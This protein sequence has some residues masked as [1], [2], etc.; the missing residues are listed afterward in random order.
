MSTITSN[1]HTAT[2][3]S[4]SQNASPLH[5]IAEQKEKEP[6]VATESEQPEEKAERKLSKDSNSFHIGEGSGTETNKPI[7]P[8]NSQRIVERLQVFESYCVGKALRKMSQKKTCYDSVVDMIQDTETQ[9]GKVQDC[10]T[11]I[12]N[13]RRMIQT[14]RARRKA[15]RKQQ[16]LINSGKQQQS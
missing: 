1:L 13:V 3:E 4:Q 10:K 14:Q 2:G 6:S 8:T 12:H 15:R 5:S 11:M 9:L 7:A 16:Q